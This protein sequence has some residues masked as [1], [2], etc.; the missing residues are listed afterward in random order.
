MQ[1]VLIIYCFICDVRPIRL[2]F[3]NEGDEVIKLHSTTLGSLTIPTT[4]YNYE[5]AKHSSSTGAPGIGRGET[6]HGSLHHTVRVFVRP[7]A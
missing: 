4:G 2:V 5:N 7:W 3:F 1:G 6:G